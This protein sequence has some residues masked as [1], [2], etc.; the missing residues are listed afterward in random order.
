M[1]QIVTLYSNK[2][3]VSK[4]TTAFNLAVYLAAKMK[5]KTLIIDAD[6]QCNITEL[7]F[8]SDLKLLNDVSRDLPGTSILGAFQPRIDGTASKIDVKNLNLPR[9]RIY[10][11]LYILRGDIE[12]SARAEG[13][14]A[15]SIEQAITSKV[16][17]K[18]TYISFRRLTRDLIEIEKYENIII[19]VGPSSGAITRLAFLACDGFFVP[20]TP[21][22]FSFL[23]VSVLAKILKEWASHDKQILGTL[24]PFGIEDNFGIPSYLGSVIQNFQVFKSKVKTS[25]Q[26]WSKKI[27]T[28]LVR[29]F[30]KSGTAT[31]NSNI[32]KTNN[33]FIAEIQDLGPLAPVAQIVGKAIFDIHQDDTT[34]ASADGRK[35]YGTV[36]DPW[37]AK[38]SSYEKEIKK[39]AE[40]LI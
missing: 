34:Y 39:I 10:N 36:W 30:I 9:S 28:Q 37:E 2:G 32:A 33:P 12:F 5:K 1:Y 29:D 3:G 25:Y 18:N 16:Y 31:V 20:V 11:N 19:D 24:A 7:F 27:R 6:P 21:D 35:Y 26:Q 40:I 23:A 15:A 8:A 13:A 14:F 22:R 38:K 4:T 17:E